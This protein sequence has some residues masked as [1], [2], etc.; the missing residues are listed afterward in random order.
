MSLSLATIISEKSG[1]I[2]N[3]TVL[4]QYTMLPRSTVEDALNRPIER[5]SFGVVVKLLRA[6]SLSL[7]DI[8]N[9]YLIKELSP[10]EEEINFLNQINLDQLTIMG[11]Q[12]TSKENFWKARDSILTNIYEGFHPTADDAKRAYRQLEEHIPEKQLISELRTQY[13]E[14]NHG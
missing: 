5:T 13:S 9:S 12:F 6:A 7:D 10:E 3:S 14:D 4:A 8:A 11:Y 1:K 2:P